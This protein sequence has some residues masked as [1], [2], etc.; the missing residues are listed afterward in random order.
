MALYR[1]V[2][3]SLISML[4]RIRIRIRITRPGGKWRPPPLAGARFCGVPACALRRELSTS[5]APRS[6]KAPEAKNAC[7]HAHCPFPHFHDVACCCRLAGLLNLCDGCCWPWMHS[8]IFCL[9]PCAL[10]LYLHSH[11]RFALCTGS[12][13][14]LH[15]AR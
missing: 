11:P 6:R 8:S 1:Y 2:S 5:S 10:W 13:D 4:L 15:R 14:R 7:P 9:N 12:Y 3:G